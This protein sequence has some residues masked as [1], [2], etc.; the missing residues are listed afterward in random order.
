V[1]SAKGSFVLLLDL[2]NNYTVAIENYPQSY[3]SPGISKIELYGQLGHPARPRDIQRMELITVHGGGHCW[4]GAPGSFLQ[5]SASGACGT[6][7]DSSKESLLF[8]NN[9]PSI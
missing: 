1:I 5:S 9:Q 7:F 8:F 4:F 2:I 3:L 6:N